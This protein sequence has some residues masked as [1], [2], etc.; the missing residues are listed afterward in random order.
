MK[1]VAM[2]AAV[3]ICLSAAALAQHTSV[4]FGVGINGG[5]PRVYRPAYPAYYGPA[6]PFYGPRY[7][8]IY[9]PAYCGPACRDRLWRQHEWREHRW[10][11]EEQRERRWYRRHERWEHGYWRYRGRGW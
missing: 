7:P 4:Y 8:V 1:R 11:R 9:G 10:W 3:V 5:G 2:L 6:Y